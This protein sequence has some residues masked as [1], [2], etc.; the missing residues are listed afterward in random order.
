LYY[1]RTCVLTL[2]LLVIS[3]ANIFAEVSGS[4]RGFVSDSTNGEVISYAN[5]VIKGTTNGAS[6]NSRGYYYIPAVPEGTHIVIVSFIGYKPKE[7][8]VEVF[9]NRITELNVSLSPSSIELDELQVVADQAVRQNETDLGLEKI[10]IREIEF[11]PAGTEVDIFK[12]IQ[13]SAGVSST[14]DVTAKYYV[15]GGSG[16]QNEVLLNG[17]TV[18]NPFHALGIFSVI[19]PEMISGL[20]FYKGGFEPK[21]GNRISSI[22]DIATKDGNRNKFSGTAQVSM[23]SGKLA[24]EGPIPDG[25]FIATVRKSYYTD[26]MNYYFKDNEAPFDFYDL[27]LKVNYAN[28]DF[29][30]GSKFV[31]HGFHSSDLVDNNDPL[32]ENYSISNT[33]VGGSWRKVWSS[34]LFSYVTASYSGYN[35]EVIPNYSDAKPRWNELFDVSLNCDFTYVYESRDELQ[36]GFHNKYVSTSLIQENLLGDIASAEQT[37][38]EASIYFN[39]KF[40]RWEK[41]GLDVGIR[42]KL[43][44]LTKN[45]PFIIEPRFSFTYL[46][47]PTVAYKFAWGVY[48]QEMITLTNENELISIFEPWIL[49]PDY[50]N[51]PQ[52]IHYIVGVKTYLSHNFT[53][54]LE[55]Y[56]KD[57]SNLFDVNEQ[58]A[59][60]AFFD[61]SNVDGESYGGDLLVKYSIYPLFLKASYSLSWAYKIVDEVKYHPRYDRRHSVNLLAGLNLGKDWEVSATWNFASG[62]PFTPIAG[63][64][65]RLHNQDNSH[66][67]GSNFIPTT[68][69]GD[70][71]S[72][73]LPV[74]HRLDFGLAKKFEIGIAEVSLGASI[75]NV[76]DRENIFYFDRDTGERINMLPFM[77]SLFVKVKI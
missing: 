68:V 41:V 19:D 14:S 35:A 31:L 44:G 58:K 56:Y 74:Y 33:V 63:F 8:E 72:Q 53:I 66:Y 17:V 60:S 67:Y 62:M 59:T 55:A 51:S 2:V 65:D 28:P 11:V 5:V 54:E 43:I 48:S 21:F 1:I 37:G 27:S 3:A 32:K 24:L 10:T 52:S 29:D 73:R 46:P 47:N 20:E 76:Y 49:V 36:F 7:I 15:R 6:S 50:L 25:S 39:Y 34:P 23:L 4:I 13:T 61:Y 30:K 9:N 71:N 45:R 57:M 38:Y 42:S 77:P 64:Y 16:D 70:K 22:L 12:V 75:I 69:W 26:V 40:Y 18:Y